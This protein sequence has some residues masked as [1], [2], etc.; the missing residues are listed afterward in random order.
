MQHFHQL[1]IRRYT[2]AIYPSSFSLFIYAPLLLAIS[3]WLPVDVRFGVRSQDI[4][5]DIEAPVL[6]LFL[7]K[8]VPPPGLKH[9]YNLFKPK[10]V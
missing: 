10:H 8:G 2:I 6:K 5:D 4:A 7:T 1:L 3:L 9:V